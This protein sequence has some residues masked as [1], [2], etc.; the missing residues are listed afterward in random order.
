MRAVGTLGTAFT[1]E[2]ER[3]PMWGTLGDFFSMIK[4]IEEGKE[5]NFERF[6]ASYASKVVPQSL[7]D[8]AR[9]NDPVHRQTNTFIDAFKNRIPWL[10]DQGLPTLNS[11][12][13]PE[14]VPP[15]FTFEDYPAFKVSTA[16][17]PELNN[18]VEAKLVDL[19]NRIGYKPPSIPHSIGGA[20]QPDDNLNTPPEKVFGG[21]G[22]SPEERNRW[23]ELRGADGQLK[24]MLERMV[25]NPEFQ[26]YNDRPQLQAIEINGIFHAYQKQAEYALMGER[27]DLINRVQQARVGKVMALSGKTLEHPYGS[28]I[29]LQ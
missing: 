27:P 29:N 8:L 13:E 9:P 3:Q 5:R 2:M 12:G 16:G 25:N 6:V 14:Q 10:R 17:G 21:A 15:G 4:D 28:Y 20:A 23:L 1:H 7:A 24:G 19:W 26:S 11:F 18:P 22:I